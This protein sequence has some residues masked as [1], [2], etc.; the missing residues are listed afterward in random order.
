[1][2]YNGLLKYINGL[3]SASDTEISQT[4]LKCLCDELGRINIGDGYIY[5]SEGA[6][7]HAS[8]CAI[9]A[10]LAGAGYTVCVISDSYG[11]DMRKCVRINGRFP[12]NEDTYAVFSRI[13]A[14]IKKHS[15]SEC[16]A[17]EVLFAFSLYIAKS[18]GADI[19]IL[20]NTSDIGKALSDVIP[21]FNYA[22]ISKM[23]GDVTQD[24]LSDSL[25][26]IDKV[27]RGVV[28]GN[29]AYYKDFSDKCQKT[30]VRMSIHRNYEDVRISTRSR[31]ICCKGREYELKSPSDILRDAVISAL[32]LVDMMRSHGIKAKPSVI[33]DAIESLP[34]CGLL[35]VISVSPLVMSDVASSDGEMSVLA[36]RVAA[37][38]ESG[39]YSEI[40]IAADTEDDARTEL[41]EKHFG[42]LSVKYELISDT[43][44]S[45]RRKCGDSRYKR[46]ARQIIKAGEEEIPV[47]VVG[48]YGFTSEIKEAY[49]Y[50]MNSVNYIVTLKKT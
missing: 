28:T 12:E 16:T 24:M 32:E 39:K 6:Y 45:G 41:I 7:A 27:N 14:I 2:K 15:L 13:R 11:E 36:N 48:G 25:K 19:V 35:D 34:A 29:N 8:C 31:T 33:S 43:P 30:G 47:L 21:F 37:F 38:V 44:E 23:Y 26:I 40:R 10:V 5:V 18:H 49:F 20:E 46:I 22:V 3:P 42:R 4:R 9:E 17:H 1:M 50:C